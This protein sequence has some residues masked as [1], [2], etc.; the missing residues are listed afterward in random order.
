MVPPGQLPLLPQRRAGPL[1]LISQTPGARIAGRARRRW[2]TGSAAPAP[3]CSI[4]SGRAHLSPAPHDEDTA[5]PQSTP[6][7]EQL[8]NDV[9]ALGETANAA[10]DEGLPPAVR[11]VL[12]DLAAEQAANVARNH[13]TGR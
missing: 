2:Q 4:S 3:G 6:D 7:D 5:I 8:F 12:D 9:A 11:E 13:G 1:H 10:R